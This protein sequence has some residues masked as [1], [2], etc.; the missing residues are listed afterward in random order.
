MLDA[1]SDMPAGEYGFGGARL[2]RHI[3]V[4]A[5]IGVYVCP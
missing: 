4:P 3:D 2:S 1:C 5:K